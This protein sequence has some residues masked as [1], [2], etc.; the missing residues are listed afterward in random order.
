MPNEDYVTIKTKGTPYDPMIKQKAEAYGVSYDLLHKQIYSES[1]F[2]PSAKSPTGP[3]GL[4]QMT[5]ATGN[6][7][8][9][10]TDAD[11]NDPTKSV[12]A[13][14]RHMK[15]LLTKYN[16]DEAM[17]LLAYNQGEGPNGRRQL[18][19]FAQ[20]KYDQVSSEGLNYVSKL[21]DVISKDSASKHELLGQKTLGKLQGS[22]LTAPL[23]VI[24]EGLPNTAGFQLESTKGI[25]VSDSPKFTFDQQQRADGVKPPEDI[26]I[27]EGT[28]KAVDEAFLTSTLGTALRANVRMEGTNDSFTDVFGS[29]INNPYTFDEEDLNTIRSANLQPEQIAAISGATSKSSLKTLI[30]LAK[31]TERMHSETLTN[32]GTGAKIIGGIIGAGYDPLSY[33]PLVGQGAKAIKGSRIITKALGIGAQTGALSVGSEYIRER[34]TGIEADYADAALG[35][36]IFGAG[37]SGAMDVGA[38]LLSKSAKAAGEIPS[39]SI[40][41]TATPTT[42]RLEERESALNQGSESDPTA[43]LG[44]IQDESI[45]FHKTASGMYYK[46]HPTEEGAVVMADGSIISPDN[47]L[48]PLNHE[49]DLPEKAAWGVN[50]GGIGEIGLTVMRSDS[51][52]IRAIGQEL[53]RS[54]TGMESGSHGLDRPV[55]SDIHERISAGDRMTYHS[56]V[57]A[58]DKAAGNPKWY[59]FTN[60]QEL[61][62]QAFKRVSDAIENPNKSH[63]QNALEPEDME[64]R[65]LLKEHFDRKL[66][67]LMHPEQFGN[68]NAKPILQG[69]RHG[70]TYIPVV[71][72][73]AAKSFHINRFGSADNLQQV[74]KDAWLSSYKTFPDVKARVDEHLKEVLKGKKLEETPES[75][76]AEL[77][78]YAHSKSYGIAHSDEFSYSSAVSEVSDDSLKGLENN[79]FLE[80]RNLF[81][82]SH[83]ILT[84]DGGTFAVND[85]RSYDMATLIPAYDRR[86]NGDI[87]IMGATGKSTKAL[88]DTINQLQTKAE[89]SKDGRFIN[90]VKALTE[91]VKIVTGRARRDPD[92]VFGSILKTLMNATFM[93][94]NSYMGALNLTEAAGL[95]ANGHSRMFLKGVPY[96]DEFLQKVRGGQASM[97]TLKEAHSVIFGKEIDESIRPTSAKVRESLRKA[98]SAPDAVVN[99]VA[100]MKWLTGEL[101]AR[102]PMSKMLGGM[103]NHLIDAG[104]QGYLSDIID[105][106]FGNEARR[107]KENVLKSASIT[108]QQYEGILQLIRDNFH[109]GEDGLVH[110]T[111]KTKFARDPRSM[112]LWRLADKLG[113]DEVILR[114]SHVWNHSTTA[115]SPLRQV[116]T[117]FKMFALRSVNGK[118]VRAYHEATKNRRTIDMLMTASI[119]TGLATLGHVA[120][121]YMKAQSLPE[122]DRKAYLDKMLDWRMLV[123]AGISR[124]SILGAPLGLANIVGAPFG[125][126][127]G[128][129]VRS[130]IV[131][132]SPSLRQSQKEGAPLINNIRGGGSVADRFFDTIPIV[133]FGASAWQAGYNATHLALGDN[134]YWEE[135][136]FRTGLYNGLKNL[137][138]NDPITQR[139]LTE[140]MTEQGIKID[141]KKR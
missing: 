62:E 51:T 42:I 78:A 13:M 9:L 68:I 101:S 48:N 81:D 89:A 21:Q 52:E 112:D 25:N 50:M 138:P 44:V 29:S 24:G 124:S 1:S 15:D 128:S 98:S 140:M 6:A 17:A 74:I 135:Q 11:F 37:L 65:D 119:A 28:S 40:H 104:R 117:Q 30:D 10:I 108:P 19:A 123:Y 126:D 45:P 87:A 39:T 55:V 63:F 18:E 46:H 134:K 103:T 86:V 107:I 58:L 23:P 122:Y 115:G 73:S 22:D 14:A 7:Y 110:L 131:A 59:H 116:V 47:P 95:I 109:R 132:K 79:N 120:M 66:D 35:G 3:R 67:M 94:K 54:P 97:E 127:T 84:G 76:A 69:T 5:K 133:G 43:L 85:L 91:V 88:K 2:N 33:I 83:R 77:E 99:T 118:A 49:A 137:V 130:S 34:T 125:F 113:G 71:Y 72:D 12:D 141:Q 106:S 75:I 92:K 57:K 82:N 100:N 53:V 32:A 26:G 56:L 38:K 121:T 96:V 136:S 64:L 27:F 90:E 20:G 16:G 41:D 36:V 114:P 93:S 61:Y 139:L 129:D 105:A 102:F 31:E 80:A 111:D 4:A 8:G 60:K 70:S